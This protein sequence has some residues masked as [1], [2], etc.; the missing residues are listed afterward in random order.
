M[1]RNLRRSK[2]LIVLPFEDDEVS[3]KFEPSLIFS[4][5]DS[6]ITELD[7][8]SIQLA[9]VNPFLDT[10]H[11]LFITDFDEKEKRSGDALIYSWKL[12]S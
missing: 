11:H 9:Q 5:T 10:D 8:R 1:R 7:L 6:E 3:E 4:M 2:H 12:R